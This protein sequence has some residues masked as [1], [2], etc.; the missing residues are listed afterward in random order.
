MD[1][2]E[3][4]KK[5]ALGVSAAIIVPSL[6]S[7][8]KEDLSP[9]ETDK[10]IVIVGG[11][12]AGLRAAHYFRQRGVDVTVLEA[13]EKVGG[14]IRTDR[15]LGIAFDEGASWIHGAGRKNPI[16][17]LASEAGATTFVTEDDNVAVF[18]TDGSQYDEDTT[19]DAEKDYEKALRQLSGSS[20]QSLSDAF[21]AENGQ[22]EGNRLW[23]FMLSSYLE[24]DSGADISELSSVA[25]NDDEGYRG[26][27]ALITNGYDT[28]TDYLQEGIT[29]ELNTRVE[30]IDYS[31]EEIMITTDNGGFLADYVIVAIPLGVLKQE[32]ITFT[33]SL[34]TAKLNAIDALQMGTVNKYLC[35][36]DT[37]FWDTNLQYIGYTPEEKGKFN[38]F[39]NVRRYSDTN[40]LMTFT[41]GDY[42]VEAE[43][44]TDAEI[45]TEITEHLQAIYGS[46]VPAPTQ[47]LRTRWNSNVNAFGCYSFVGTGG[48]SSAYDSLA[49]EVDNKLFFAGEHTSKDYRGT[50][51]GAYDSG[52]REAKRIAEL[53][54]A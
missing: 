44:K 39:L 24:F 17:D 47:M 50:V 52:E 41:F 3:F 43:Q 54:E 9:I 28:I 27:E 19:D 13:Q 26:D 23:T 14:R 35:V 36:W 45:I 21:Y 48:S 53:L 7:G 25:F 51:H 46:S 15:S 33:P 11:G 31:G 32:S 29:V 38:Y 6:F 18:D 20:N 34:P 12:I 42:S 49:G 10:R 30:E 5:S 22:Y 40:A 4:I 8:C 37:A 1:R 16:T 2:R